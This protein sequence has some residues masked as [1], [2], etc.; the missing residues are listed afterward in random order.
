MIEIDFKKFIR[1]RMWFK[2]GYI[3]NVNTTTYTMPEWAYFYTGRDWAAPGMSVY[4]TIPKPWKF[5]VIKQLNKY[6]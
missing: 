6:V 1:S 2:F 4:T 5:W 3:P